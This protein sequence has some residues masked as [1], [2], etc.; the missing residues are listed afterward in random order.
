MAIIPTTCRARIHF[1]HDVTILTPYLGQ[2][3]LIR[4]YLTGKNFRVALE[5]KDVEAMR[6]ADMD[7]DYECMVGPASNVAVQSLREIVRLSTVDKFQGNESLLVFTSTVRN[8]DSGRTGFL[9]TFNRV[10]RA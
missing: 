3:V 9:K 2:L 1:L 8:N 4:S 5:D 6:A 7:D 10:S